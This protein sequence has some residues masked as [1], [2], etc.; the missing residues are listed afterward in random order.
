MTDGTYRYGEYKVDVRVLKKD[1]NY[2]YSQ[3][4]YTKCFDCDKIQGSLMMRAR[5]TGDEIVVTQTGSRKRLKDYMI[6]E[7]IPVDKRDFIPILAVGNAVLWVV[8]LTLVF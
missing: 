4:T 6:D 5:S 8:L 1:L 2:A 7:K 3:K